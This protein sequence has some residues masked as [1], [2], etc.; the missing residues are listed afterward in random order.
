MLNE[1]RPEIGSTI[2]IEKE[3]FN[4]ILSHLKENGYETIGPR[5]KN[6]TLIYSPI[7][8]LNDLPRGYITEQ[9]AGYFRLDS[10]RTLQIF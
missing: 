6:D 3:A 7:E 5:V 8:Q 4:T 1:H 2:V 10:Y 9:D